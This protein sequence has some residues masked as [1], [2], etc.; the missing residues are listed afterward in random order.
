[1]NVFFDSSHD[2]VTAKVDMIT[3]QQNELDSLARTFALFEKKGVDVTQKQSTKIIELE[4]GI[5]TL[6]QSMA[7][8]EFCQTG[9]KGYDFYYERPPLT[10]VF[11]DNADFT[12]TFRKPPK[13]V[14][15]L[16]AIDISNHQDVRVAL[17]TS[18]IHTQ[19]FDVK[20]STWAESKVYGV[21]LQWMACPSG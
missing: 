16:T 20:L 11:R 8:I 5:N 9:E 17:T 6:Q 7:T 10:S 13:V 19:K 12:K 21:A 18:S 1:M 4:D 14:V 15:A 3:K 2:L